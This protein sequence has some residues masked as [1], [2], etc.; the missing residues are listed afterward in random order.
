MGKRGVVVSQLLSLQHFILFARVPTDTTD[1]A[2][3]GTIPVTSST[4]LPPR[5]SATS[6]TAGEMCIKLSDLQRNMCISA[7]VVFKYCCH[8]SIYI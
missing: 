7:S 3:A 5:P 2:S 6:E 4:A 1:V 8:V